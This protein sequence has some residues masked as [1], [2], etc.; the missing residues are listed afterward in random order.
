MKKEMANLRKILDL[1]FFVCYYVS[2]KKYKGR[3]CRG[4]E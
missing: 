1:N 2:N 3:G 4:Q